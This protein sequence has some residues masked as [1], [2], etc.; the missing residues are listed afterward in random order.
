MVLRGWS[1]ENINR[2]VGRVRRMWKFGVRKQM[3]RV[4]VWQSLTALG[5][6]RAGETSAPD[7]P[8]VEACEWEQAAA[9]L[10]FLSPVV[11][12]MV[13]TQYWSGMR[14][15]EVCNLRWDEIDESEPAWIVRPKKHKNAWRGEKL[16]KLILPRFHSVLDPFRHR[17]PGYVFSSILSRRWHV[18]QRNSVAERTSKEFPC[19]LKRRAKALAR[20][21]ALADGEDRF[22]SQTYGQAI[23]KGV[24]RA[25]AAGVI[26]EGFSP[27]QLRH[28]IATFLSRTIDHET[29]KRWLGHKNLATTDLYAK[30][31]EREL[32]LIATQVARVA[33]EA[34][35]V[36]AGAQNNSLSQG[37]A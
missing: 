8:D 37:E 3:V 26:L 29:A 10:P 5:P 34:A 13:T 6:L 32:R 18:Q 25:E 30:R 23:R 28:G 4:D 33:A 27:N 20:T 9:L 14:P 2:Q 21:E 35:R 24:K 11:A 36:D 19:E 15:G 22:T 16:A 7:Y 31:N 12:A 1:R 17:A